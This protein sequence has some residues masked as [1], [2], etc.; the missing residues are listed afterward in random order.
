MKIKHFYDTET[1][2]HSYVVSDEQTKDAIIIDPVLDY[3]PASGRIED[4]S[5]KIIV[6]YIAA[7]KLRPKAILE[8][9]AHADHISSSQMLKKLFPSALICISERIKI[10]QETFKKVFNLQEM[11]ADGSQ[12]DRL[13]KDFEDVTLGS[14][15][16]RAIP[17]PGHTPA[18]MSYYFKGHVFTGDSL[19]MPD[20][21]TGRCDFPR[22]SARDLYHSVARNLYSLPDETKVYVGHDY[23]PN[24]REMLY[25]TTIG[26][27]KQS[28][29]QLKFD[30]SE[31]EFIRFRE[32][33]DKTLKAPRLLLP[34]IQVN[35]DGGHLP[36]PENNGVAYLKMP[37][38]NGLTLVKL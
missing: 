35:I 15:T 26:E 14:L 8:T 17:T 28:N 19:F 2:T 18:C 6:D 16:F 22:G 36:R 10:V 12:F 31:E 27:S 32:A 30:T 20:S 5:L 3:D 25:Q 9:H 29:I 24:G 38:S 13:L 37:L 1:A 34:S 21:G 23:A 7:M 33:R 11:P 4:R